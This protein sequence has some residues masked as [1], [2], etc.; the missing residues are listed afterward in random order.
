MLSIRDNLIL[1]ITNKSHQTHLLSCTER[2]SSKLQKIQS[3]ENFVSIFYFLFL[4][5]KQNKEKLKITKQKHV[6]QSKAHKLWG[7]KK[8]KKTSREK[9]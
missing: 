6:K 5:E 7:K 3:L 8:K 4:Y 9:K 1:L 2:Y